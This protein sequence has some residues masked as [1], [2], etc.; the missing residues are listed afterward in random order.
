MASN[1]P[2]DSAAPRIGGRGPAA[3]PVPCIVFLTSSDGGRGF[4]TLGRGQ[5]AE[6][7]L[8]MAA[9]DQALRP[10]PSIRWLRLDLVAAWEPEQ[11]G[12]AGSETGSIGSFDRAGIVGVA[13]SEAFEAALHPE[14]LLAYRMIDEAGTLRGHKTRAFFERFP[15]RAPAIQLRRR[16]TPG[17]SPIE[18]MQPVQLPVRFVV[19]SFLEGGS[20]SNARTIQELYRGNRLAGWWL[21]PNASAR[22]R[23]SAIA[24]GR[25]LARNVRAD[26]RFGYNFLSKSNRFADDY[27]IL[28]HAGATY[29]LFELHRATGT[30]GF[31]EAAEL[32]LEYLRRQFR[33][34]PHA[35]DA[36]CVVEQGEIKL[37][38][39][40]LAILALLAY[41]ELARRGDLLADASRLGAGIVA[42]QAED[43][44]FVP[45]KLT[46][47]QGTPS[48]LVSIYYPGEACLALARLSAHSGDNHWLEAAARAVSYLIEIRDDPV[49]DD[50]LPHD[51]WLAY[52]LREIERLS[53]GG[54]TP[55]EGVI[56]SLARARYARRMAGAIVATQNRREQDLPE[57]DWAGGFYL[58][59]RSAPTST[60][61]EGLVAVVDLLTEGSA[62]HPEAELAEIE[63]ALCLA[64]DYLL[65]T[66]F[67][68]GSALF[69]A[70][71]QRVLGAFRRSLT[72]FQLRIDASQHAI[73]AL[74]GLARLHETGRISCFRPQDDAVSASER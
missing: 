34:C 52:A 40:A 49:E 58:P 2:V 66:Q 26:G 43:G 39:N 32:G 10:R 37:G 65:Q 50:E 27:N 15:H 60:R 67:Q 22:L 71:P 12:D 6:H 61:I 44:R 42:L 29:S 3:G 4:T 59:P 74:L 5:T 17:Q 51:H 70:E 41:P 45:Q 18:P 73:S 69:L 56:S 25:Y 9:R 46:W 53:A 20:V 55:T 33:S 8:E 54:V 11:P 48:D 30:A 36:L 63:R 57:A 13:N 64:A 31:F 23:A 47:P 28:R 68:P 35:R 62:S 7:A 21:S 72:D 16:P 19:R 38:G 14:E 1:A 24:A